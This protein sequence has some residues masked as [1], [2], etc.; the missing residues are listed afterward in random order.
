MAAP[1]TV[2]AHAVARD[3]SAATMLGSTSQAARTER[4]EDVR[5]TCAGLLGSTADDLTFVRNTTEGLALVA[6]G[7][8]WAPGDQVVVIDRD[9]PLT[10]APWAALADL[11]VELIR[12]AADPDTAAVAVA[13]VEAALAASRGRARVVVV[14]W[15]H[16]ARGF[17]HDLAALAEAAHAHGA[18]LVADVIQGA[19]VRPVHLADWGVDAAAAGA[20]KWLL[21]PEG[22]GLLHTTAALR[23]ELR[24]LQPGYRSYAVDADGRYV[25][26][27]DLDPTGRRFE[28][29]TSAVG[30]TGGLG[31][32]ADLL[33]GAGTAQIWAHV[34]AWCDALVDGLRDLGATVLSDRSAGARSSLVAARFPTV[35]ADELVDRLVTHGVVAAAW[36]G[37]VRFSPHGWNDDDDLAATLRALR[38]ATR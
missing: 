19:G 36:S 24:T 25:L 9:H 2:V 5:R 16:H 22:I 27:L 4:A 29:G 18:L 6:N 1:P 35:D 10:T 37:A 8:R 14:A 38:R 28:G 23:A 3:A 31:A 32:S 13:D 15:V 11:G 33:A 17:R 12:V 26:D 20:Q 21:G 34:D 30:S 7:L